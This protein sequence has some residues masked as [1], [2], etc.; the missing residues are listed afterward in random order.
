MPTVAHLVQ[1]YV[2][3]HP[4]LEEFIER[5]LISF[6]RL[7]RYL[8]KYIEAELGK[9]VEEG[10][11]VMALSRMREK[12]AD[13]REEGMK[14]PGMEKLQLSLRSGVMQIDLQKSGK[15]QQKLQKIQQ[16]ASGGPEEILSITQSMYEITIIS[17]EK[18][19]KKFLELLKGEKILNMEKGLSLLVLR[20]G[21]DILYQPGFFDRVLRELAWENVNIFEIISTLTELIIVLKEE[22]AGKAYDVL[23]KR[24]KK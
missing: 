5:D 8:R 10:S 23:R 18:Y 9:E 24:M 15:I 22:E 14:N 1:K 3:S 21:K 6:H 2:R 13:K 7:A 17:S 16:I 20:F 12:M 11:V 4:H 19:E